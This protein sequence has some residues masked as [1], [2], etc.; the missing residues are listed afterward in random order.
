MKIMVV[1]VFGPSLTLA[2]DRLVLSGLFV[3]NLS[4]SISHLALPRFLWLKSNTLMGAIPD[5]VCAL[6]GVR[7]FQVSPRG[8]QARSPG[9]ERETRHL[10]ADMRN[11]SGETSRDIAVLSLRYPYRA[12]TG[13]DTPL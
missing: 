12:T 1:V 7:N 4:L 13:C 5:A 6:S 11:L 9:L 10:P 3:V 2:N 8:L